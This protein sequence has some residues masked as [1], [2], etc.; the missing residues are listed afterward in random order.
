[1]KILS[2]ALHYDNV[3]LLSIFQLSERKFI[4]KIL[5]L[6]SH[7]A[8]GYYYPLAAAFL[9]LL[10]PDKGLAFFTAALISFAVELP[11]CTILKY[12]IKRNRPFE[13]LETVRKRRSP[14]DRFSLPSGHTAAAFLMTVLLSCF[15]PVLLPPLLVWASLV[16]TSRIYLGVHYPTDVLAGMALGILSGLS[17]IVL[18][19]NL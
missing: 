11:I 15:F 13:K 2:S 6:A 7:T 18:S 5:P 16:G 10:S 9:Y 14:G 12:G 17:G 4:S 1:M 19:G 3:F 8:N